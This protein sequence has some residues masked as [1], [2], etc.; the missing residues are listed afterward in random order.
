MANAAAK[1]TAAQ[2]EK[3]IQ[4]LHRSMATAN[5]LSIFLRWWRRRGIFTLP[6]GV[7]YFFMVVSYVVEGF[8]YS[9]LTNAGKSTTDSTGTVRPA[10]IDLANPGYFIE[11]VFDILYV[12]WACQVGSALLGEYVWWL[13]ISIPG[14]VLY[15]VGPMIYSFLRPSAPLAEEPVEQTSKRQQKLKA[16]QDRGDPREPNAGDWGKGSQSR[17]IALD[18]NNKVQPLGGLPE[19]LREQMIP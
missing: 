1:K 7:A 17:K 13:Y 8:A 3:A 4:N 12:T 11:W 14:Y 6:F 19:A 5:V 18:E 15:K 2:N 10:S 9:F 16:R